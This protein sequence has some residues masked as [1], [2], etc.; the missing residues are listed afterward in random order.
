[1]TGLHKIRRVVPCVS[2]CS[3]PTGSTDHCVLLRYRV[4][5]S[6]KEVLYWHILG[7]MR[8]AA[9][10]VPGVA[11]GAPVTMLPMRLSSAANDKLFF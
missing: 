9:I 2:P 4:N 11:K 6:A 10:V 7:I 8:W 1:M 3:S 5:V